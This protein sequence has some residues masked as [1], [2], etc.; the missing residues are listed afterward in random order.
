MTED[1]D[2]KKRNKIKEVAPAV[3]EESSGSFYPSE[4]QFSHQRPNGERHCRLLSEEKRLP[5]VSV[6]GEN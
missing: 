4:I 6:A 5:L 3:A 2:G 1:D